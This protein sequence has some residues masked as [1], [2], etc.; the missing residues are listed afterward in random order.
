[1]VI[2]ELQMI[3]EQCTQFTQNVDHDMPC[4]WIR[5]TVCTSTST[6]VSYRYVHLQKYPCTAYSQELIKF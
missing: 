4:L 1:M 5:C 2:L 6:Y 3:D